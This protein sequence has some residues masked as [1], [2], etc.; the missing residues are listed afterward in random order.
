METIVIFANSVKHGQHCV[1]GKNLATRQWIRPVADVTGK[2]LEHEQ[3]KCRN[4]YGRFLV[5]PLQK[6]QMELDANVPLPHQPENYLVTDKE[7]IQTYKIEPEEVPSFLDYPEDLWGQGN[8]IDADLVNRGV[9]TIQQSLYLISVPELELYKNEENK[10]RIEF[11]YNGVN[12]D[13]PVTDPNFD[14]LLRR[15][16]E[17]HGFICV[18]LGEEYNGRHYKIVAAII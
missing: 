10:R 5:K 16:K 17:H 2:E 18:S 9:I 8:A 11:L 7:W 15:E 6:I 14:E 4:P 12:Y 13:L 3:A 1:A